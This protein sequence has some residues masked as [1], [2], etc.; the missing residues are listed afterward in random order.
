MEGKKHWTDD[1]QRLQIN[2]Q[3]SIRKDSENVSAASLL[4]YISDH[5]KGRGSL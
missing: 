3:K 4:Q 2:Q 5:L 1:I